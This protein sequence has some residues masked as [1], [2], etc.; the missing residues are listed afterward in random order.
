VKI[1]EDFA[2]NSGDKRTGRCISMDHLTLSFSPGNFF[3]KYKMTIVP[4]APYSPDMAPY[5]FSVS[6]HFDK[7][8]MIKTGLQ[9][10]L[11]ILTEHDF[12]AYAQEGDYFKGD[13]D[14]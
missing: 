5:S 3:S 6:H 10:V 12:C 1:C 9:A 4:R 2:L 14:Q 13:G 7:N 11:N 8:E